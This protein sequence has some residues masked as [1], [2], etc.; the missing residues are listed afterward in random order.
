MRAGIKG[1]F[2][3]DNVGTPLLRCTTNPSST[4]RSGAS[5][6]GVGLLS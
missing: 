2:M 4:E 5:R 3:E 6:G 1:S